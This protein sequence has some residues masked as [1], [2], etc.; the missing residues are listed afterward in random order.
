MIDYSKFFQN[1]ETVNRIYAE[2]E[3][4]TPDQLLSR[5]EM[6]VKY[7]YMNSPEDNVTLKAIRERLA[8]LK[9]AA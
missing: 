6:N 7:G 1:P 2:A 3:K 8:T 9:D 4:L 5:Y